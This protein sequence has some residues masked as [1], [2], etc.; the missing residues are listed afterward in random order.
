MKRK[1]LLVLGLGAVAYALPTVIA[2]AD[3]DDHQNQPSGLV[4][5]VRQA[6]RAY[7]DVNAAITAGYG[8]T[9]SCV[10]GPEEGAMGVHYVDGDLLGDDDLLA[11]QPEILVYEPG[12]GGRL[13]LAAVEYVV[14]AATWNAK[15]IGPPVLMGQ[16]FHLVGG[17]NRYGPNPFYELHVWAW[18]NNPS[19]MFADWNPQVSCEDYEGD[20]PSLTASG[21]RG[22]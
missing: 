20:S 8:S 17:P 22:H 14:D 19:G 16:H 3:T 4:A 2:L 7:R 18:K 10:S 15:G 12:P 21:H 13:R 5:E 9:G 11:D 6:T 1:L